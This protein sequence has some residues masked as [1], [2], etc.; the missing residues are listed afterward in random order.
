MIIIYLIS[1]VKIKTNFYIL[2]TKIIIFNIYNIIARLNVLKLNKQQIF[3]NF[4][5]NDVIMDFY[6]KLKLMDQYI[7][8][9]HVI[10]DF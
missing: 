5:Y 1:V 8:N 2:L 6:I 9:K 7:V 3:L 4:V 10:M